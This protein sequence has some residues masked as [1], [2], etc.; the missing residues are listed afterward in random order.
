MLLENG[1][2]R[3]AC[4]KPSKKKKLVN[5]QNEEQENKVYLYHQ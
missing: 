1:A 3:Y 4:H 2:D 5:S